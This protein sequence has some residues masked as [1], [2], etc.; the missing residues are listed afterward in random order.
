MASE[1]DA[2]IAETMRAE[3]PS[4]ID[5]V[6]AEIGREVPEY[7][8]PLEGNFGRNVRIGVREALGRF[9][10][11]VSD[12][13]D[14]AA[15]DPSVYV[16]LGR[17]EFREGRTL[18]ALLQAYRVGARV[19]WRRLSAAALEAGIDGERIAALAEA[20]FAY[21]DELSAESAEGF[22]REQAASAGERQ[23]LRERLVALLLQDPPP[24]P[25]TLS[26]AA[27]EAGWALPD[28][29]AVIAIAEEGEE[30]A[31]VARRI[32]P[33][34]IGAAF[35]GRGLVVLGD[36]EG[37]GARGALARA[38]GEAG[39]ALGPS[40]P[41]AQAR[42][43]FERAAAALELVGDGGLLIAEEHLTSLLLG[44]DRQIASELARR[45]LAPFN[46][47]P[48]GRRARLVETLAAW[49]D[50]DRQPTPTASELHLHPQTVRYRV[51][52]LRELFG[53][54]LEDP[55]RRFE[56]ALALRVRHDAAP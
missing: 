15:H 37:P 24:E 20:V 33:A 10:E 29:L 5:E 46:G 11:L 47:V 7:A 17:G 14:P 52:Q 48:E 4:V 38:L 43:S 39:G 42:R 30:P 1:A 22:A 55:E 41:A 28:E 36:P 26:P 45:A 50:N 23:R 19:A 44:R 56:L 16:G 51:R 3:L 6:I 12:P 21:I 34:A 40:V 54:A 49:L 25:A 27:E 32:G 18:N 35:E 9:V 13:A 8:R 2:L 53:E 31:T